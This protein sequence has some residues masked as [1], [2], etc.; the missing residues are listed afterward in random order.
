MHEP[1]PS[2][3]PARFASIDELDEFL[4]RPSRA[5]VD[6]LAAVDGDLMILGVGG[7]MGPTLARLAKRAAPGKRV[8]G[9]ARF[10]DAAVKT[11]LEAHGVETIA[12]DLLERAAIEAL[13]DVANVIFA[14]G[15]K[16][17]ASGN[18]ALT[19]AMN[20]HVPALVAERYRAS[21]IVAFS[22]G[23]VYALSKVGGPGATEATAPAPVGDYAQSCLGRER[24]FEYFSGRFGT[25]GRIVRLNYAIDMRYGVLV[26]IAAKIARGDAVDV[27]MGHVNVIW[28]GD[29]NAQVLGALAHCTTPTTPI[30]CT[31]TETV[32]VRWAA[33]ELARRM[34]REVRITGHEAETALLSD[35]TQARALF[36][37]PVV[38][39]AR[40]LDWVADWV[41]A[42]GASFNKPTKFEVRDGTF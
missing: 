38:P 32:A 27:T 4:T 7:K 16:F 40:M 25:A 26:D 35:T 24:M 42:G 23:N 36:G 17:G 41:G 20:T 29:A 10:S 15:H 13:P 37:E 14:A 34:G 21:R 1:D 9:A 2:S 22:T 12:C 6:A 8:I 39:L 19:W 5:L 3:L 18:P 33:A 28:Q 31:G 30:N 11:A